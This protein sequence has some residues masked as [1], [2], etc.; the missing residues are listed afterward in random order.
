MLEIKTE[1]LINATSEKVWQA[2]TELKCYPLWNP[3][4]K[5]LAGNLI[6][7]EKL[8]VQ[9]A[10]PGKKEMT[11]SPMLIKANGSELR[12]VGKFLFPFLFKGEHYFILEPVNNNQTKFI[13]GEIFNGLLVS[14]MEK[15]LRGATYQGFIAM[16]EALKN[17]LESK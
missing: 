9:I 2:L 13:H 5:N 15:D 16:N 8:V 14:L 4:I 6:V 1:I 10:P 11:F 7:G 17:L 3:F 12:W